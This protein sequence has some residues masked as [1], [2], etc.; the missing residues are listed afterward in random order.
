M[1]RLKIILRGTVISDFGL[2]PDREYIGGRKESCDIRLQP[3]KGISR[4]HFKLKYED[5]RWK[6]QSLSRFG[7]IFSLGQ[8]VELIDL[9]H[10]QS[11]QIPPYEFSYSEVVESETSVQNNIDVAPVSESDKT[12][13]GVSQQV[14][15]IK[16]LSSQGEVREMLRLEFGDI[17]VA[18]RD[19]SCQIIIPDQ[20]VSRRQF[21]V[22][23]INGFFTIIDMDSVNGTFLNGSVV[24]T[25]DPVPLKSGDSITVLDN[26]MYFEL[27]DPNFQYRVDK[28]EIPPLQIE[29]NFINAPVV[30]VSNEELN[31]SLNQEAE[32]FQPSIVENPQIPD[33]VMPQNIPGGPFTGMPSNQDVL[34][35]SQYY[36]FQ[37]EDNKAEVK[38][39]NLDKLK[40]NK[41]V[42]FLV[43]ILFLSGAYFLSEYLNQPEAPP[44]ATTKTPES[45]DAFSKLS[46]EQQKKI[47]ELYEKAQSERI[48]SLNEMAKES[49]EKIH[50]ILPDGYLDSKAWLTEVLINEQTIVKQKADEEEARARL[51]A[52]Q[53][54]R[55]IVAD[56]EKLISPEITQDRILNCLAEAIALDPE[57]PELVRIN[58][59]VKQLVDQQKIKIQNSEAYNAQVAELAKLYTDAE[60]IRKDGLPYKAIKSYEIVKKSDL[61]DPDS[62]KVRADRKIKQIRK[63]ISSY[64]SKHL[65]L[66]E[67][68]IKEGKFKSAVESLREA[69]KYDPEN[70]V[71]KEKIAKYQNDLRMQSMV[72]FQESIVDESF[73]YID[74]NETRPGAKEKWKKIM[75]ID[76]EDGEYYRKAFVKLKKYG[77][78]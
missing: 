75:E 59:L 50:Q 68:A 69:L 7:E 35:N 43:V 14:P 49:L 57:H 16:M 11:F 25:T 61:P 56:C 34:Q 18:G 63:L 65:A 33:Y 77:V 72:L 70:I 28:I 3:E 76:I 53:K 73:G 45:G 40:A 1:S 2:S 60:K 39:S 20:R 32:Q 47:Q 24:S 58:G 44:V 54:I 22:R 37:Q 13:I 15:Y 21:E 27:H 8:R 42:L 10:G 66:A 51:E 9:E 52:D 12:V 41:P 64:S 48:Q 23:K 38:V 78:F 55:K 71:I 67:V 26:T 46:L 29:D 36:S 17:W 6:L 19:S 62:L 74:G 31:F 30:D 5:G 4:E